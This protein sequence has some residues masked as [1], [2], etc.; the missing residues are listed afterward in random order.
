MTFGGLHSGMIDLPSMASTLT[1]MGEHET[2]C[3]QNLLVTL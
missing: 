2:I 3:S 1:T